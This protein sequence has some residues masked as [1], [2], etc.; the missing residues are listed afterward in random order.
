MSVG[1]YLNQ[2]A[3]TGPITGTEVRFH[4]LPNIHGDVIEYEIV[5]IHGVRN[6]RS[7]LKGAH[8]KNVKFIFIM[9]YDKGVHHWSIFNEF[10]L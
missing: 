10:F 5:G 3:P 1:F 7:R 8:L 4:F 6:T 2:I 9:L